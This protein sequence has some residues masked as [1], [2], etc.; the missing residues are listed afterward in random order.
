MRGN[1]SIKSLLYFQ[2]RFRALQG[3][4]NTPDR[5]RWRAGLF[6]SIVFSK[7]IW[8]IETRLKRPGNISRNN[9]IT[10]GNNFFELRGLTRQLISTQT[11]IL[12][13]EINCEKHE[14]L[15]ATTDVHQSLGLVSPGKSLDV[16]PLALE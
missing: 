16:E 14:T 10:L 13:L 3:V 6:F 5:E 1:P 4:A 9:V 11:F 7:N 15:S 2:M 12:L 8:N